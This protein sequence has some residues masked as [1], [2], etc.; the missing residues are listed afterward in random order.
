MLPFSGGLVNLKN[1]ELENKELFTSG[2]YMV[3]CVGELGGV[4]ASVLTRLG[5]ERVWDL[6]QG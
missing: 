3:D 5:G 1:R 2:F 6:R 4:D